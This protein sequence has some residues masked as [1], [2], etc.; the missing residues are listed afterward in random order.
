MND[1][2][3]RWGILFAVDVLRYAIPASLAFVVC[4]RWRWDALAHR[5]IQRRR[6]SPRTLRR[7]V[8]YSI[9]TAAIFASVGLAT[10]HLVRAGV[11]HMYFRVAD[12]GWPYFLAS[13]ALAIVIHDAYFYGTHRAMHHRWLFKHVHRVHHLSTAPS[14]WAAYAFAPAEALVNALIVPLLLLVLP[15][16]ELA[17]FAFL[18]YMIVMNVIGHLGI[19][20]YPRGFAASPWTGWYTTST[21]HNLHHRDFHGNYGLY[22][23]L[24]DKL[25]G[26]EHAAYQQTFAALTGSDQAEEH[27]DQREAPAEVAREERDAGEQV[28]R[29]VVERHREHRRYT[30]DHQA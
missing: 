23:T 2:L 10:Y 8:L 13:I 5:R 16:H 19:E 9:S 11:L 15:M 20:L 3:G 7:E 17:V 27:E 24:W 22:S 21:H 26:T 6:P 4:W 14:P 1:T 25:M 18:V 29:E 28:A 30:R 12:H